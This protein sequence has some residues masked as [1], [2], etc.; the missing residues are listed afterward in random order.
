MA[1]FTDNVVV[2]TGASMGLGE[3]L[4]YQFADQG[5][6]LVLAARSADLL[7]S[8]AEQCRKRGGQAVTV[9]GDLMDEARCKWMIER[10]VEAYG[11]IDTL[12]YNA[13]RG[14]PRRFGTLANLG[15]L[16]TT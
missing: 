6:L 14:W 15:N 5:A 2:L 3:Q 10:A 12:I 13:G 11:R 8:V 7:E 1:D 9:A 16:K 4:A